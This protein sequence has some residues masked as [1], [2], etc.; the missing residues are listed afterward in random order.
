MNEFGII[1]P[2]MFPLIIGIFIIMAKFESR[3]E[4]EIAVFTAVFLNTMFSFNAMYNTTGVME[5]F[6][7][8]DMLSIG[9]KID[10]LSRVFGTMVSIL[11]IITTIYSFEYMTHE[12]SENRFFGFFLATYGVVLG[13]AFSGNFLTMYLFYEFLTLVT[14]P[15]VMHSMDNKARYAG[16]VYITYMMFGAALILTGF[17]FLYNYGMTMDFIY[18]GVL[19]KDK[20]KG[21]EDMELMI[22]AIT[23]FGFG[24]K[25]AVLPMFRWLP[26]ASIAPTPVTA[27]LHAVAVVK[28]GIFAIIRLTYFSFG[29][30]FLV[31]TWVQEFLLFVTAITIIFGSAVAL[32]T[33]HIKRRFAYSTISNL[34]YILF[35][36]LLMTPTG[37]GAGLL[38][39]IYHAFI[40]IT[41]FFA[42]GTILYKTHKEYLYEIEGFAYKMPVVF[43]AMAVAGISL[44]G[45]PPFAGFN[46]KWLLAVAATEV[47]SLATYV[48]IFA[49]IAS[50]VMTALY[51]FY[52]L[53]RGFFP[54]K[55]EYEKDYYYKAED[56]N[57]YMKLPLI[58]LTIVIL[59]MGLFPNEI[60]NEFDNMFHF[61]GV[62][63]ELEGGRLL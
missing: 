11:W 5:I 52:I 20:I 3:Q 56:P 14:L 8:Q 25:S 23:F 58:V 17:I 4:R 22:Y 27:L 36:I 57:W 16:K 1:L 2:I 46:S 43:L 33:P 62:Y 40:K 12:G 30:E 29:T 44:A 34:S 42:T 59:I 54:R 24:V 61:Y 41:L 60:L 19:S 53:A 10:G 18:G 26:K 28:S 39:M 6:H 51:M 31:G 38:H 21:Q 15:L 48:G 37:L 45:I 49:L 55:K 35:G 32:R 7:F 9:L 63:E 47:G 13:I 50:S